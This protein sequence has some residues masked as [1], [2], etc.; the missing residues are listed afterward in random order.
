MPALQ[1]KVETVDI[2]D[3]MQEHS[4][5]HL[6]QH[7]EENTRRLPITYVFVALA[8]CLTGVFSLAFS[9]QTS[10]INR[11]TADYATPLTVKDPITGLTGVTTHGLGDCDSLQDSLTEITDTVAILSAFAMPGDTVDISFY[12]KN[13][14]ILSAFSLLYEFDT[15]LLEPVL[16]HDTIIDCNGPTC[17]TTITFFIWTSQFTR[18]IEGGLNTLGLYQEDLPN[19][20]RVVAVPFGIDI[21]SVQAGADVLCIQR[22]IVKPNAQLGC[23]G[24]FDFVT[25]TISGIDSTVF[26]PDTFTSFCKINEWAVIHE[27]FPVEWIPSRS[28]GI[29]RVGNTAEIACGD[30]NGDGSFNVADVTFLIARI[31]TGGPEPCPTAGL[32]DVNCDGKV[33]IIDVTY[34]IATIFSGGPLPCCPQGMP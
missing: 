21:D 17:D 25:F 31:F 26:P 30:A 28:A 23:F 1:Y 29:F 8:I 22:F 10:I 34:I 2:R 24:T 27:D 20:A 13:D 33:N 6:Q 4:E 19:L 12:F 15:S 14:S 7:Q 32:G 11:V 5:Q 18:A 3:T 9:E 16:F